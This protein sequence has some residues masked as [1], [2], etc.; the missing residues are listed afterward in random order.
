MPRQR[1]NKFYIARLRRDGQA[2]GSIT[3]SESTGVLSLEPSP[4]QAAELE[5]MITQAVYY[6]VYDEDGNQTDQI[7]V[8]PSSPKEYVLAFK[9]AVLGHFT[10]DSVDV[11]DED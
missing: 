10:C 3:Y 2:A 9:K 1:K 6:N 5:Q 4:N 11:F 7:V 8:E